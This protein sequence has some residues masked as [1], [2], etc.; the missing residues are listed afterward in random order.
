MSRA[1]YIT[2]AVLLI[3]LFCVAGAVVGY[4]LRIEAPVTA[5]LDLLPPAPPAGWQRVGQAEEYPAYRLNEKIDGEDIEFLSRGCLGLAWAAYANKFKEESF[6]AVSIYDM[7]TK[8]NAKSIYE[9]IRG[10]LGPEVETSRIGDEAHTIAGSLFFRTDRYYV[11]LQAGAD[12]SAVTSACEHLARGILER[13][14]AE[15]R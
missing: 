1:E 9:S 5:L 15:V 10:P 14:Q 13:I 12:D 8:A 7:A 6:I 2:S 4:R 3:V 11:Q